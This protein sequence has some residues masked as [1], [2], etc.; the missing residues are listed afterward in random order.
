[1]ILR[2]VGKLA[3]RLLLELKFGLRI[4]ELQSAVQTPTYTAHGAFRNKS[5]LAMCPN[6]V[7]TVPEGQAQPERLVLLRASRDFKA[8][9]ADN[10]LCTDVWRVIDTD[11]QGKVRVGPL[12][13]VAAGE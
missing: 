11:P 13:T 6:V 5:P 1:M 9:T 7:Y 10:D 4:A 12:V 8:S 2:L 3:I